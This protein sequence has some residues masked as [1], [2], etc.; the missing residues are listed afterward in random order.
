[1]FRLRKQVGGNGRGVRGLVRDDEDLA[2]SRHHVDADGAEHGFFGKGDVDVAGA[3]DLVHLGDALRAVGERGYG[4]RSAREEDAI[5][6]RDLR[7]R[8]NLVAH[9]AALCGRRDH[10]KLL[11]SRDFC[12][13]GV[14]EHG[15]GIARRAAGDV[16]A[17][18]LYGRD[19]L[20]QHGAVGTGVAK[21]VPLLHLVEFAD[22]GCR[23]FKHRLV[24]RRHSRKRRVPVFAGEL[25]AGGSAAVEL[26]GVI[27]QGGIALCAHLCHYLLHRAFVLGVVVD[28][29]VQEILF[30]KSRK[31]VYPHLAVTSFI[32]PTMRL[33]S[34]SLNL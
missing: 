11:H 26:F 8:D 2:R 6:T 15:A 16:D 31:I 24:V 18:A 4:A 17:H 12:G 25:E 20:P 23:P 27:A 3:R 1:M 30:F 28:A 9:A 13:D 29:A 22:V 33:I 10:A 21:S 19:L 34:P 5:H 14:H 7:R 32:L